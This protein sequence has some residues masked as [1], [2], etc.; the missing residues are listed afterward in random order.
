[1]AS[2][3]ESQAYGPPPSKK[4]PNRVARRTGFSPEEL[5][6]LERLNK[7]L[8]ETRRHTPPERD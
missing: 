6:V 5:A 1:M 2:E 3:I 7:H 4:K 8:E